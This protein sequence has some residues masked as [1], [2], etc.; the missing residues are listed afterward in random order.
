MS[1]CCFKKIV[2]LWY[3][4]IR[5]YFWFF[6]SFARWRQ[7]FYHVSVSLHLLLYN[8]SYKRVSLL[9]DFSKFEISILLASSGLE[10][11]GK[12]KLNVASITIKTDNFILKPYYYSFTS[13]NKTKNTEEKKS[14]S[15]RKLNSKQ[16]NNLKKSFEVSINHLENGLL[17]A[18]SVKRRIFI[19]V[20]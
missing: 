6:K 8:V 14:K 2:L 5:L 10:G 3:W 7:A 4:A 12:I 20:R 16:S 13:K 9:S 15:W 17:H 11:I 18:K 1:R 19:H